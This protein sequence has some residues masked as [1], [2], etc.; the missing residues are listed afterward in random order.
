[1]CMCVCSIW[2]PHRGG[3]CMQWSLSLPKMLVAMDRKLPAPGAG[4]EGLPR[5]L[6][7]PFLASFIPCFPQWGSSC[8]P[9]C[10]GTPFKSTLGLKSAKD[11]FSCI[12]SEF[13]VSP[14]LRF[15]SL[16]FI[17]LFSEG[18][19]LPTSK[20]AIAVQWGQP[21]SSGTPLECGQDPLSC[22]KAPGRLRQTPPPPLPHQPPWCS[23]LLELTSCSWAIAKSQFSEESICQM[24]KSLNLWYLWTI[25]F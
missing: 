23:L 11:T 5:R 13:A 1:M 9:G 25:P 7:R 6:W 12:S 21:S 20:R 22:R 4:V 14:E 8:F 19:K 17:S 3:K 24:T 18:C 10:E 15:F 2:P 16:N